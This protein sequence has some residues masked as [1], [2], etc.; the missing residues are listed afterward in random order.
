MNSIHKTR[1]RSWALYDWANSAFAT[2]IMAGFFPV[3]FQT[4]WSK[5]TDSAQTT[6]NLGTTLAISGFALAVL[7]PILGA[8]SDLGG[9]KKKSLFAFM[10]VGVL[11]TAALA[12]LGE[13]EWPKAAVIYGFSLFA[14]SAA[15]VFYD[16]LL[17]S[18]STGDT[19]KVSS[20]GFAMGYL[21]GGVL[22]AINVLMFQKPEM[23]GFAGPVE[24]V[25]GSFLTVAVWWLVFSIPL[26][27]FVPEPATAREKLTWLHSVR[28]SFAEIASTLRKIKSQRNLMLFLL[29]YWL[30]IDGVYTVISMAVNHG[31]SIGL[32]SS[33]LITALLLTQFV[34]AP[35]AMFFGWLASR[36]SPKKL[37]LIGI[38]VYAGVVIFATQMQNEI[39]FY[40]VAAVIGLVQG[41]V[42]ALS[43]SFY[44]KMIPAKYAGEYFGFYNLIGKFASVGGPALVAI[45]AT[46]TGSARYGILGLLVLFVA[47]GFILIFV[48]EELPG[49]AR[50]PN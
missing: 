25:K 36:M 34:G 2:T 20:L 7:A 14:F 42:Q 27:V 38:V 17:P 9:V 47:G 11:G 28:S 3:F 30:Y 1:V 39:Q 23:F 8:T 41:G 37:I 6:A 15:N 49:G 16:S 10:M 43:R 22:L 35:S 18:V 29:A 44:A 12:F 13:G 46:L 21:G 48:R 19:D 4:Y 31:V 32:K 5:G 26:F 50:L 33:A 24:A 45:G 40:S